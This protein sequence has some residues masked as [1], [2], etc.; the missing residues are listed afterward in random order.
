[1]SSPTLKYAAVTRAP[2]RSAF[3]GSL[4][5][6]HG[7]TVAVEKNFIMHSRLQRDRSILRRDGEGRPCRRAR[8]RNP[9]PVIFFP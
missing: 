1:M 5:D 9:S 4:D 2:S 6:L 8:R 3:V 7:K